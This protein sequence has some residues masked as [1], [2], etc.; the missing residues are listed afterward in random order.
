V[1][2]LSEVSFEVGLGEFVV[3]VGP[4][5]CGKSTLLRMIADL[6]LPTSGRVLVEGSEPREARRGRAFGIVFQD[7]VLLPWLSVLENVRLPER[8]AGTAGSGPERALGLLRLV[9]LEGFER[10]NVWELSGGMRQRVAIARAL[11]LRPR[12]LLLD[13]P[14]GAL[15]EITRQRMNV[16]LLRIWTESRTT[17]LLVTHSIPEAAF[18]AD[19]VMVMT[20]RPGR[21]AATIPIALPRP[22]DVELL[23]SPAFFVEVAEVTRQLFEK[24]SGASEA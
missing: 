6:D 4:S 12:L 7:P 3:L 2:A 15:D 21:I 23:K 10:A 13:E 17:A 11:V 16:E 19:R 5:G 20:P 1:E 18:L 24:A 9:G 14:F 8:I 22:R